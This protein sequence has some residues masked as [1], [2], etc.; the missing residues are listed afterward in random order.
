M[1]VKKSGPMD[2]IYKRIDIHGVIYS[3]SLDK[4]RADDYF[5]CKIGKMLSDA[6]LTYINTL[7]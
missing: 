1:E 3:P 6:L 4:T 7:G 2:E 5:A